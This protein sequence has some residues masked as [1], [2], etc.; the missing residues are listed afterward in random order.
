MPYRA[1]LHRPEEIEALLRG[2]GFHARAVR[3]TLVWRVIVYARA[4][5]GGFL[6]D[7]HGAATS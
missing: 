2:A 1:F 3:E 6:P 5:P 4:H 7:P